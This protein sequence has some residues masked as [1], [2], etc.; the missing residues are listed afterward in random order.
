MSRMPGRNLINRHGWIGSALLLGTLAL[1][2]VALAAWKSSELKKSAAAAAS[3]PEPMETATAAIAR[4]R[5]FRP[6][7]TSI[8]TVLAMQSITLENEIAGTVHKVS[9]EPGQIV[10][11]GA[12]LVALDVSVEQAELE[13]QKAQAALAQ[14]TLDRMEALSKSQAVAQEEV[15]QARAARDVA[16]AQIARTKAIIARKTIRAPFRAR[17]GIADVHPGQYLNEGTKLTTL[18][19]VSD[20]AHV[21]FTVAQRVAAG[22]HVGDSVA[23]ISGADSA[24]IPARIV[25]IDSRVDPSTRNAMVRAR[26][27]DDK[28]PSPGASVRVLVPS[29]P[30]GKA[31]AIPVSALRKGP[32]GDEVFVIT[33]DKNG[34]QRAHTRQVKSGEVM[35]DTVLIY[36]GLK[37]GELVATSGSFKLRD[38]VLVMLADSTQNQGGAGAGAK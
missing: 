3:Q 34:K 38:S 30:A 23:V 17:V 22:L 12:L 15:D 6:T 19:G 18:Q 2:G 25:A 16:Q 32:G 10:E 28:V 11:A 36:D 1:T 20:N 13:A 7:T 14:T 21:D 8:G 31:V 26:I 35:G 9:L 37:P 4:P 24:R 5:D 29:G 33:P 27:P